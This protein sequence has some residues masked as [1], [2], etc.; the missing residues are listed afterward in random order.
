MI[1][2]DFMDVVQASHEYLTEILKPGDLAVDLTV[3]NGKDSLFLWHAV[4]PMGCVIG[5]DIQETALQ[6]AAALL[7]KNGSD[8]ALY[9]DKPVPEF[10]AAGAHLILAD[11][12]GWPDYV[13]STPKAVIANLGYLP[14]S[15]H[16]IT[17]QI[18]STISALKGAFERLPPGGRLAVVCYVGHPGGREEAE[19]VEE[20]FQ[21]AGKGSFRVT[22]TANES[23]RDA[24]FL[25]VAE[26]TVTGDS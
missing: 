11:H 24:P 19:A 23:A 15:D 16:S 26:K 2:R 20:L 17:T 21:E 13:E 22:K 5:F 12:A 10:L 9:I 7:I 4:G 3:G 1:K 6:N 8:A 25:M 14:G 18:P